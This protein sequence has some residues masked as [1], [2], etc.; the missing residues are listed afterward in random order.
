M[1]TTEADRY[2]YFVADF[3]HLDAL[4][5]APHPDDESLGCGGTIV[6]HI[7]AGSKVKIVFLT[8]GDKGDFER[9][10]GE[11]YVAM[12]SQSADRAMTVLGVV[13]YEFWGYKDRE[14]VTVEGELGK[15]LLDTVEVFSPSIIYAPS[16]FEAHPDHR[17]SFNVVWKLRNRVNATLAFYEVL[18]A[19]YPNILIDITNEIVKKIKAI[20]C[21]QTEL[22]YNDYLAKVVGLNRFRTATLPGAITYAEAYTFFGSDLPTQEELA[23][24]LLETAYP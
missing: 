4:I 8:N 24:K 5:I 11:E 18:I 14:L 7:T 21:Y 23:I 19:I 13:D 12:R 16:S 10:F 9:R 17:C 3:S 1:S 2:P 20:E 22:H 6:K 15:R